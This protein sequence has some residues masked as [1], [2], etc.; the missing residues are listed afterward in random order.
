MRH[1]K[2]VMDADCLIKLT[3]VGLNQIETLN[4]F[5]EHC[6]KGNLDPDDIMRSLK[7]FAGS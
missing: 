2:I 1:L 7:R 3:K 5:S 4:L 6:I